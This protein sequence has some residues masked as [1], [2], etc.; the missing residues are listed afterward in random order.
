MRQWLRVVGEVASRLAMHGNHRHTEGFEQ[1]RH[2]HASRGIDGIHGHRQVGP[3]DGLGIHEVQAKHMFNVLAKPGIVVGGLACR[4]HV[5]VSH[6]CFGMGKDL[7][8]FI[9]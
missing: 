2:S 7:V 8:P 9:P 6:P 3:S 4:L 5:R 1:Q